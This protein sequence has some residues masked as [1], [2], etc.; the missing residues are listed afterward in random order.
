MISEQF[1]A[2]RIPALRK[3]YP[4]YSDTMFEADWLFYKAFDPKY[5]LRLA[6]QFELPAFVSDTIGNERD[7]IPDN[8]ERH[9]KTK[10]SF[11]RFIRYL[12]SETLI[13]HLLSAYPFGPLPKTLSALRNDELNKALE[14]I[15]LGKVPQKFAI[16]QDGRALRFS[17]WLEF[18]FLSG[19]KMEDFDRDEFSRFISGEARLIKNRDAVNAF[20]HGRIQEGID[21]Q[22]FQ[23][24]ILS[25]EGERQPIFGEMRGGVQW[26]GWEE[27][28]SLSS[29]TQSIKL[30]FE[31]VDHGLDYEVIK[32]S[33]ALNQIVRDL[34]WAILSGD[35]EISIFLPD[36][37]PM[38][39][40]SQRSI[41]KLD[42]TWDKESS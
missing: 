27:K 6:A 24:S 9:I 2:E 26:V 19:E 35:T 39:Q 4:R 16:L 3:K 29:L 37:A 11:F 33:S 7:L 8:A 25:D 1:K 5:Y 17:E 20:K 34:R 32:K 15:S 10:T 14:S 36:L 21:G 13:L 12:S 31:E 42:T 38:K 41:L 28:C 22:P 40:H 23:V 18:I 30:G